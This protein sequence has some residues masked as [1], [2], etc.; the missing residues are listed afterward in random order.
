MSGD[1]VER[2]RLLGSIDCPFGGRVASDAL[3]DGYKQEAEHYRMVAEH[4]LTKYWEGK[5]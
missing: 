5:S 1:I 3:A 4:W 2:L